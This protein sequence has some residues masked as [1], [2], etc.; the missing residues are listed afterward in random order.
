LVQ[1]AKLFGDRARVD[2]GVL[3]LCE[4]TAT[5]LA[6]TYLTCPAGEAAPAALAS[7]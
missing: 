5:H 2:P 1:A 7:L 4:Q 3:D 6:A